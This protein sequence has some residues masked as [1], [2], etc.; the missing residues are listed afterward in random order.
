MNA[1]SVEPEL[2]PAQICHGN[3]T[4]KEMTPYF[5]VSPMPDGLHGNQIVFFA[6]PEPVFYLPSVETGLHDLHCGPIRIIGDDDIL[7]EH[8]ALSLHSYHIFAEAH[9]QAIR[10]L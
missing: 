10:R 4:T 9:D 1:G 8:R 2:Y 7:S 5:A 3:N 6:E